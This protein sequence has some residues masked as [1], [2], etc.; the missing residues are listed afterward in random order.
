MASD[1]DKV[2]SRR[3]IAG[4][5]GLA[6]A[7]GIFFRFYHLD[8]K[9]FW[10]D[11]VFTAM[12]ASGYSAAEVI[13]RTYTGEILD[14]ADL[15]Q[16]QRPIDRSWQQTW[17]ALI[18][19]PEQAPLY[20]LLARGWMLMFGE[21]VAGVAP[22]DLT[23]SI[24]TWRSLSAVISL[25]LFPCVYWLCCELFASTATAWIA[26]ALIALSPFY[27]LF[28]QEARLYSLW[29]VSIAL[30]SAALLRAR[31][32]QRGWWLYALT[33]ALSLYTFLFS[34]LVAIGHGIYIF[35]LSGWRWSKTITA[36][37]GATFLGLLLFSPWLVVILTH[38]GQLSRNVAHLDQDQPN[39]SALWLL[40]LSRI[41]FDFN[42]GASWIN[43]LTYAAAALSIYALYWLN[44]DRAKRVWLFIFA[45][46]GVTGTVLILADL[47]LGGQR[48]AVARYP[49]ACYLG[50][51]LAV[52]RLFADQIFEKPLR[53]KW[54]IAFAAV[55]LVGLLSCGVSSQM[56]LW[57][58]KGLFKTRNNPEIAAV[59][60]Q[61]PAPLVISDAAIERVLSLSYLLQPQTKFQ[62]V[63][64][65]LP[66]APPR[67]R[68]IFLYQP[69]LRLRRQMVRQ[70]RYNL[71]ASEDE[72][73]W[74][75]TLPQ[76]K[77]QSQRDDRPSSN[78][79]Q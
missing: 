3:W 76:N 1:S 62:L 27:V 54:A 44:R 2:R 22:A 39:L 32:Q 53:R 14:L 59:I 45:L 42:H 78:S 10:G 52:A 31:H 64:M 20:Y 8:R 41:F 6:L 66:A 55:L 67:D 21:D 28:A 16:Y 50:I 17:D 63:T 19:S 79:R 49:I 26:I 60:N 33:L 77:A 5:I 74:Q 36:Y 57:W 47:V 43:P 69:S 61:S 73:L 15:Q 9:V 75:A 48:S 13:E 34:G 25:L 72:W 46:I 51:Q 24:S 30:S 23:R 68:Q 18:G 40:N 71:Q 56:Q 38:S 35:A 29:T 7:W 65:K 12:R 37:L 4:A 70:Y 58:N 11:E